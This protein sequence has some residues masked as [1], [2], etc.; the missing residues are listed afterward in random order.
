MLKVIFYT[1]LGLIYSPP[2]FSTLWFE[3]TS[4]NADELATKGLSVFPVVDKSFEPEW[5]L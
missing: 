1:E 4:D 3:D 2:L 5:P